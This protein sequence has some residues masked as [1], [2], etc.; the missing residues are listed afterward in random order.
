MYVVDLV[1]VDIV[2]IYPITTGGPGGAPS[3]PACSIQV[4]RVVR[5]VSI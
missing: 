4:W 5:P 2:K 1:G 3:P